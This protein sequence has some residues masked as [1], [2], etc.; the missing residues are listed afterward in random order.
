MV[1]QWRVDIIYTTHVS[2]DIAH[3][4]LFCAKGGI[5]DIIILVVCITIP[6]TQTADNS[7]WKI[8]LDGV[9]VNEGRLY[10]FSW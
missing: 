7:G 5:N 3:H 8:W 6:L 1:I 9:W 2:V 10:V 4:E